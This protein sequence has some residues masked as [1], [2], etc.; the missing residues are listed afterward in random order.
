MKK[1]MCG[2]VICAFMLHG[3]F[4]MG[5]TTSL[6]FSQVL[7]FAGNSITT[8]PYTIGTVPAG[9][10][11]KVEHMA[12]YRSGGYLPSFVFFVNGVQSYDVYGT[13][14]SNY[15]YPNQYPKGV[16]WLKAGDEIR[17]LYG[18][19]S[20]PANYFISVIEFSVVANP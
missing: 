18:S 6:Q 9:K 1:F 3:F 2:F 5:Q 14:V 7:T 19:G 20:Y 13:T 11:W 8:S 16:I 10:V 12:G 15:F 4:A 17:I